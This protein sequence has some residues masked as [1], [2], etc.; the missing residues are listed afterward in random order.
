MSLISGL[1]AFHSMFRSGL[2]EFLKL[3]FPFPVKSIEW[4][5][6]KMGK[7]V[8][9]GIAS[10]VCCFLSTIA[11]CIAIKKQKKR[12]QEQTNALINNTYNNNNN[13][14]ANIMQKKR[15]ILR[16]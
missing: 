11:I 2:N 3:L 9:L 8:K 14:N 10:C 4:S 13:N 16:N 6:L 5:D 12:Q 15:M 7:S 1:I